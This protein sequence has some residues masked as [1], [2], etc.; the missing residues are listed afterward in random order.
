MSGASVRGVLHRVL[1][2]RGRLRMGCVQHCGCNYQSV[3][4]G[5]AHQLTLSS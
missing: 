3:V 2:E 5:E 4:V 1:V